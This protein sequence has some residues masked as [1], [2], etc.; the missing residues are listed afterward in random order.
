MKS[1]LKASKVP[2]PITGL[3]I[4]SKEEVEVDGVSIKT[5]LYPPNFNYGLISNVQAGKVERAQDFS[6]LALEQH[7]V[8]EKQFEKLRPRRPY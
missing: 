3:K 1:T 7:L 4:L 8:D 5:E 6:L 2:V